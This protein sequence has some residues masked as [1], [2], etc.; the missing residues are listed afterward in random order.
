MIRNL[1][2]FIKAFT[3]NKNN[4]QNKYCRYEPIEMKTQTHNK[5]KCFKGYNGRTQSYKKN[6]EIVK[7]VF[8]KIAQKLQLLL[9]AKQEEVFFMCG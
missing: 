5:A 3:H 9:G 1:I 7:Y 2:F 8:F 6:N 4:K